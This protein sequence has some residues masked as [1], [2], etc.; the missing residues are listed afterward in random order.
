M[1][2]FATNLIVYF[3]I[4]VNGA[5]PPSTDSTTPRR[6]IAFVGGTGILPVSCGIPPGKPLAG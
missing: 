1:S 3:P 2:A 5:A 6:E 4:K